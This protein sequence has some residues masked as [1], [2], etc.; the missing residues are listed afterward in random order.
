MAGIEGLF[1][2]HPVN[3]L[4]FCKLAPSLFL[5]LISFSHVNVKIKAGAQNTGLRTGTGSVTM[6]KPMPT[7]GKGISLRVN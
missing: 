4:P 6:S 5:G 1:L 3:S 7:R 2:D